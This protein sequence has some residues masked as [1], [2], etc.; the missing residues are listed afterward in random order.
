METNPWA[1]VSRFADVDVM[2]RVKAALQGR[3]QT[4][5]DLCKHSSWVPCL[6]LE[7]TK[8]CK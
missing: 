8:H 1:V 4:L 2:T 3:V 7:G 5:S 6:N